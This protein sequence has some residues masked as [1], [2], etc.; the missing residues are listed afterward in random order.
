MQVCVTLKNK[1]L[2]RNMER[3][4]RIGDSGKGTQPCPEKHCI[5]FK[6]CATWVI[7]GNS[8]KL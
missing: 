4:R 7:G 5:K 1:I 2:I 3:M 6:K 8:S